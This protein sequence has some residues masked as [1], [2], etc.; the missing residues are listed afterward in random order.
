MSK[1]EGMFLVNSTGGG[2]HQEA[3]GLVAEPAW[4]T[5]VGA[6]CLSGSS[7]LGGKI[8]KYQ[9]IYGITSLVIIHAYN[10]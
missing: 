4:P 8:L 5:T 1:Q 10:L 2:S 6:G 3:V 9:N 7:G